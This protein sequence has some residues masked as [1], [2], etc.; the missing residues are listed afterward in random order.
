MAP[1]TSGTLGNDEKLVEEA[2]F[3]ASSETTATI[4]LMSQ[5][6]QVPV[7][8]CFILMLSYALQFKIDQESMQASLNF[9][10]V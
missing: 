6:Y 3:V 5:V 8:R 9:A 1:T 7:V 4:E 2:E 10:W